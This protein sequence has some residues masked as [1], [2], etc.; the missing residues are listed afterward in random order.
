MQ[1]TIDTPMGLMNVGLD[2]FKQYQKKT[3]K[4]IGSTVFVTT[5]FDNTYSIG[6]HS[7]NQ[8]LLE[9]RNEKIKTILSEE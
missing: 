6:I 9:L 5:R 8:V 7:W 4:V 2:F 3:I 1:W